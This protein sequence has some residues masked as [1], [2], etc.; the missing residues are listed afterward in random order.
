M[1]RDYVAC[2]LDVPADAF[3]VR[4]ETP[5]RGIVDRGATPGETAEQARAWRARALDD[6]AA[7]YAE[8][9]LDLD[10]IPDGKP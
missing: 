1:V 8:C 3:D 2:S 6:L 5:V 4:L 10:A 9:G 7:L